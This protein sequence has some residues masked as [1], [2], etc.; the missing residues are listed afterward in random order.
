MA[1][2]DLARR[3][4]PGEPVLG[5]RLW[6]LRDGALQSCAVGYIWRP[7]DNQATCLAPRACSHPPGRGCACGLWALFSLLGCLDRARADRRE[8]A[9]VPGLI[10]AWGDVA[11]HGREGFRAEHASVACLFTDWPWESSLRQR[12]GK[13]SAYWRRMLERVGC[14]FEPVSPEPGREESLVRAADEYGVPLLSLRDALS[15]GLL[16]ELGL[17]EAERREAAL[18]VSHTRPPWLR[19]SV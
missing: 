17:G 13:I 10:R 9:W 18:W 4:Q 7:G 1:A 15:C 14:T 3:Q 11:L 12:A 2:D 16:Q 19:Q 8:R 5:W 6:R